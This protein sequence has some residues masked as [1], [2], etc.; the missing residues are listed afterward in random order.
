TIP[1]INYYLE[2]HKINADFIN[3]EDSIKIKNFDNLKHSSFNNIIMIGD[4]RSLLSDR[5]NFANDTVFYHN[6]Y[7]NQ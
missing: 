6:P 2:R 1:L 4:Y 3:V 5:Y 7:M